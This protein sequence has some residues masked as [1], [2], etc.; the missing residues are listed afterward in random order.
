MNETPLTPFEVID[1]VVETY[2]KHPENRSFKDKGGKVLCL[3]NGP[4]GKMCAFALFCAQPNRLAEDEGAASLLGRIGPELLQPRVKH[5][6]NCSF[7]WAIQSIHDGLALALPLKECEELV[8]KYPE[9]LTKEVTYECNEETV[10][11]LIDQETNTYYPWIYGYV[12]LLKEKLKNY[13]PDPKS[14][15]SGV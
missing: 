2:V 1:L 13:N 9:I 11:R 12:E 5:I 15:Q 6:L 8:S 7:W 10:I 3:Y 4:D 14:V